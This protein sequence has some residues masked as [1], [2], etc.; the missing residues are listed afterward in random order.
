[1]RKTPQPD[2]AMAYG[3]P[4]QCYNALE[5]E[6]ELLCGVVR[7]VAYALFVGEDFVMAARGF[8]ALERFKIILFGVKS[9]CCC[10]ADCGV[11]LQDYSWRGR[12]YTARRNRIGKEGKNSREDGMKPLSLLHHD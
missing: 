5:L 2:I 12:S 6:L 7:N 1:M 10:S 3:R 4:M 9:A 8:R 11:R